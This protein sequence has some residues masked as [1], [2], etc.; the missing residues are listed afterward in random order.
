MGYTHTR[1]LYSGYG[2]G[3]GDAIK[4]ISNARVASTAN[5]NG[6]QINC[7]TLWVILLFYW[8]TFPDPK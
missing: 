4:S 5:K 8:T 2:G 7:A 6:K 3:Y 1:A